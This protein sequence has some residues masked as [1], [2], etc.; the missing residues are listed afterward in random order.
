MEPICLI[1]NSPR[2]KL[3]PVMIPSRDTKS[4]LPSAV[5]GVV[6]QACDNLGV[7]VV[8][9]D[10]TE[11]CINLQCFGRCYMGIKCR[12]NEAVVAS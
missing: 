5:K 9:E 2:M 4:V 6:D 11:S 7:I 1:P 8:G 10:S 12:R 3:A